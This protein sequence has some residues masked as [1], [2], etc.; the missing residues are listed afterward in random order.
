MSAQASAGAAVP[1]EPS[2]AFVNQLFP[3]GVSPTWSIQ[4]TAIHNVSCAATLWASPSHKDQLGGCAALA[5][6][7][8]FLGYAA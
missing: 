7:G 4:N 6:N 3:S 8:L 5:L 2:F 1:T